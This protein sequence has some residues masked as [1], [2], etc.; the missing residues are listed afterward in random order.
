MDVF[1]FSKE[2]RSETE[3]L[4]LSLLTARQVGVREGSLAE[5]PWAA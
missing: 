2:E 1:V 4:G 5:A 3:S